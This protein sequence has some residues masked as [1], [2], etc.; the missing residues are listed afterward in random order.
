MAPP[1]PAL[2]NLGDRPHSSW[3]FASRGVRNSFEN[4]LRAL[5]PLPGKYK[6]GDV[7]APLSPPFENLDVQVAFLSPGALFIRLSLEPPITPAP[8]FPPGPSGDPSLLPGSQA[9]PC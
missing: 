7:T 6:S 9:R 1:V 3:V 5:E 4:L 8:P 2:Q